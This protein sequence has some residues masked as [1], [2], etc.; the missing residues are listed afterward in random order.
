MKVLIATDGSE[1]AEQAAKLLARLPHV[2]RL[3]LTIVSVNQRREVLGSMEY[4]EWM[5]RNFWLEQTRLE[6]ACQHI[7]SM[8]D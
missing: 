6:K 3:D 1:H 8:F 2:D 5:D 4:M 7:E